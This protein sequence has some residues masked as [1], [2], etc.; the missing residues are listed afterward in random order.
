MNINGRIVKIRQVKFVS[1]DYTTKL[2][3]E[4]II[5]PDAIEQMKDQLKDEDRYSYDPMLR[6]R[7][8]VEDVE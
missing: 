5:D 4:F 7:L 8:I 6:P 1:V 3:H 2:K